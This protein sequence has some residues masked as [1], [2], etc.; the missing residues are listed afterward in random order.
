MGSPT[1]EIGRG[2]N[3]ET[4]HTVTFSKGFFMSQFLV[5]Q[6]DYLSLVNTNPAYFN[7]NHSFPMDL[8]RPIE[9]VA[10]SD[11]TNYC[12]LLTARERAAGRIFA[13]WTYRLPTESE[14]EF[15]CRA[16]TTNV[17]YVGS[18]LTNGMANFD[19]RYSYVGGTGTVFDTNGVL[20]NHPV[21]VGSYPPNPKG[22]FDMAGNLWE[23]C[24]DWYTNYPA[25][26]V[27]DPQGPATGTQR[28]FRGGTFNSTGQQCR[29]AERNKVEPTST[30]N[31]IGF[32]VVLGPP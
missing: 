24:S 11:A 27:V 16:G 2:P 6:G 13:T 1:N 30:L 29:S 32:R 5:R 22:L 25:S 20:L 18:T 21:S 17:F 10:W 19:S 4:R 26:P 31:T 3:D 9:Q 12:A 8:T 28:V 15:A 7:T 14:W 23:W